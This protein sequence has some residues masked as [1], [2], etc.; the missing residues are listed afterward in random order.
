M[1]KARFS[2]PD[3]EMVLERIRM[4][5][6]AADALFINRVRKHLETAEKTARPKLVYRIFDTLENAAGICLVGTDTVLTGEDI[7][8]HLAG[9]DKAALLALTLGTEPERLLL[10]SAPADAMILDGC[11]SVLTEQVCD[12]FE[13]DLRNKLLESGM[14]LTGRYSPG[15]GDLPLSLQGEILSILNAERITGLT[16]SGSGILIPRKSVTAVLGISDHSVPG[17]RAGCDK[18]VLA[19]R[20]EKRREGK[21]CG[22]R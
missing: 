18:C 19:E 2:Q 7:R 8:M 11:F 6:D 5:E 13:A 16:V 17:Y 21:I 3:I 4:P 10:R 12:N 14:Y 15:Y 9:C 22:N 1:I 20:C